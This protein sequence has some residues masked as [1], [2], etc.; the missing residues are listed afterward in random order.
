MIILPCEKRFDPDITIKKQWIQQITFETPYEIDILEKFSNI[1]DADNKLLGLLKFTNNN[2]IKVDTNAW[3]YTVLYKD[4]ENKLPITR[5]SRGEKLL[6]LCLMAEE[7]KQLIYVSY[8]LTQ[9]SPNS[10]IKLMTEFEDSKYIIL[11]PPTPTIQHILE[12]INR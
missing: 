5:L 12:S 10:I 11:V 8:E 1:D 4:K 9:L 3:T 6:A 2:I 7:T